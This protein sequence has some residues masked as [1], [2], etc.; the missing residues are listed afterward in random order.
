MG[1]ARDE[2]LAPVME[3]ERLAP[4]AGDDL[5]GEHVGKASACLNGQGLNIA[6]R[7]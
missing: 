6:C 5:G 7:S 1:E 3:V 4:W 2:W